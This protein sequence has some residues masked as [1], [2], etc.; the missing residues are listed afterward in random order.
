MPSIGIFVLMSRAGS[1]T[2]AKPGELRSPRWFVPFI[3]MS[4][5]AQRSFTYFFTTLPVMNVVSP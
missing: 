5:S 4:M 3:S 1:I 2:V